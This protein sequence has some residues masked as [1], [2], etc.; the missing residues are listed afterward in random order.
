MRR[1]TYLHGPAQCTVVLADLDSGAAALALPQ[2]ALTA[3]VRIGAVLARNYG[4]LLPGEYQ[5]VVEGENGA[6]PVVVT[7]DDPR[8]LQARDLFAGIAQGRDYTAEEF[9]AV[10]EAVGARV[11]TASGH[12][13]RST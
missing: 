9:G 8:V 12:S 5:A 6:G 2:D 11:T 1:I 7:E 13:G 3:A 10:R 4:K